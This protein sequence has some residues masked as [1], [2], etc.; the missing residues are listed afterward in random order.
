MI[1][2]VL[3]VD[4]EPLIA[5][6][7]FH[8]LSEE[9]NLEVFCAYGAIE[10]LKIFSHTRID[11][12]ISD[13]RMPEMD[14][15]ELWDRVNQNWP[16]CKCIF[17]SAYSQFDY[18]YRALSKKAA[19]YLLKTED[20]ATVLRTVKETLASFKD[21]EGILDAAWQNREQNRLLQKRLMFSAINQAQKENSLLAALHF[22]GF[23]V[24]CQQLIYL[25]ARTQKALTEETLIQLDH[26]LS[27]Q[28]DSLSLPFTYAMN[29]SDTAALWLFKYPKEEWLSR[30]PGILESVQNYFQIV[31]DDTVSFLF[32][33]QAPEEKNFAS[34]C[35]ILLKE[36][37]KRIQ[38]AQGTP[39]VYH[40]SLSD[41]SD[42]DTLIATIK[43]YVA[44]HIREDLSVASLSSVTHYN[45]DYLTRLFRQSTGCTLSHY[46]TSCRLAEICRLMKTT[47]MSLNEISSYMTF[48]SRS[49]FNRFIKRETSMTPQ[50]LILSMKENG[51]PKN[52]PQTP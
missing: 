2:H 14:G 27:R 38:L 36:I 40:F 45:S 17:L 8:L 19:G 28:C 51:D 3:V 32:C 30:L 41:L 18:I 49:Y 48:S 52:E 43:S 34:L 50:E 10:A 24:P 31:A 13:I 20:D 21:D 11:L 33:I 4:D 46:I 39:F 16:H 29:L 25:V 9:E 1:F 12:L 26:S 15:L 5:D 6:S 47:Q 35:D 22:A 23:P 44:A 37:E 7:I 42:N